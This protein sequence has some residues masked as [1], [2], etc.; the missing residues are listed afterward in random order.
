MGL[1]ASIFTPKSKFKRRLDWMFKDLNGRG[2]KYIIAEVPNLPQIVFMVCIILAVVVYPGFWQT[3]LVFTAYT[4][5]A[6]WSYLEITSGH[7]RFRKLLGV[8][9][10]IAVSLALVLRLGF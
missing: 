2:G 8:F 3:T 7:S 4:A 1:E 9:G 6:Y 5:L 10:L